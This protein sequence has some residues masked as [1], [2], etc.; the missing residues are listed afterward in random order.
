MHTNGIELIEP[1][2][3]SGSMRGRHN[4]YNHMEMT[5]K[6]AEKSVDMVTTEQG[7]IRKVDALGPIFDELHKRGV[8]I[9]IAAPIV[10][11]NHKGIKE[12]SKHAEIRNTKMK[13]RFVV[14]DEKEILFMINDDSDI[15]PTYDVG[16]WV[17]TPFFASALAEMFELAWKEM[18][19][20]VKN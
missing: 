15:H 18:K 19:V 16:I 11:L 1:S 10:D 17:N 9:R 2:E 5:I 3:L 6:S 7:L 13:A 4:L 12:A 20:V 14:V 8:K